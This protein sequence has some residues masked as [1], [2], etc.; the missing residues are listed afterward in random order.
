MIE[1]S[2]EN[3]VVVIE[4]VGT[5]IRQILKETELTQQEFAN[6]IG[7]T[8]NYITKVAAGSERISL[9]LALL[10]ERTYGY[11]HDWILYGELPV[12]MDV[13]FQ[14]MI[15]SLSDGERNIVEGFIRYAIRKEDR[16]DQ[17]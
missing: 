15:N 8:R 2:Q 3:E 9:S 14:T 1:T 4:S 13:P 11:S 5:R 7:V 12:R 17:T 10:I 16:S 6:D